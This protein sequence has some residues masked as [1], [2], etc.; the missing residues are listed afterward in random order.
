MGITVGGSSTNEKVT[1]TAILL[2]LPSDAKLVVEGPYTIDTRKPHEIR[3]PD[4]V[5]KGGLLSNSVHVCTSH[6]GLNARK[7]P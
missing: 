1:L 2:E 5:P 4:L 3:A 6:Y 7:D